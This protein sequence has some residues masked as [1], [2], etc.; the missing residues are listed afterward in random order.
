MADIAL[1]GQLQLLEGVKCIDQSSLV[2][3]NN[4]VA[5]GFLVAGIG[6]ALRERGW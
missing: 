2:I 6:Q 5:I 4:R 3:G 1:P